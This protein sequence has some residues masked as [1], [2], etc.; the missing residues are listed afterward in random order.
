MEPAKRLYSLWDHGEELD[1]GN[2]RARQAEWKGRQALF[3]NGTNS[4]VFIKEEIPFKSYR[5][6]A[7]V[8][9][10]EEVGFIGLIFG[11]RDTSNYE[12]VYMP[13]VEIQYDPIM[14]GSM[15]WQIYNGPAYQKP[16]PDTTGEWHT[17][18]VEVHP[19]GAAV[20]L[21]DSP[22]PQLVISNLQHGASAGR[23]GFWNFLPSY[24]RNLSVEEIEPAAVEQ[25][26]ALSGY[27][28][29]ETLVTEWQVSQPYLHGCPPTAGQPWTK[30]VVE[31][32]GTLNINRLYKAEPGATLE[33]RAEIT[34]AE[35]KETLLSFGFSDH[36]RLW[37]NEQE[38]YQGKSL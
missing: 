11:A 13:P 26:S 16:L 30:A 24:I 5:L 29:S 36:L 34:L 37:I 12:L 14:N 21:D 38:V 27:L 17:F 35:E 15:T 33:A 8:A 1:L 9:I 3:L 25:R 32:N 28:P 2:S 4:P 19:H 22:E 7:E 18:T 20:Y 6:Q 23:I 10:P 31:E